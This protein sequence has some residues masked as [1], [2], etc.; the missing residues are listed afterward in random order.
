M[1]S[2]HYYA[3]VSNLICNPNALALTLA[4]AKSAT[5]WWE[6]SEAKLLR[7]MLERVCKAARDACIAGFIEFQTVVS[8]HH[9]AAM[10]RPE[11]CKLTG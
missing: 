9:N 3:A 7:L 11:F 8:S 1:I 2:G 5:A 6:R 10:D 4:L